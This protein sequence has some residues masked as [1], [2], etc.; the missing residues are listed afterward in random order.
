[1]AFLLE[2]VLQANGD[3]VLRIS[4]SDERGVESSFVNRLED[5]AR[6]TMPRRKGRVLLHWSDC[7]VRETVTRAQA[8]TRAIDQQMGREATAMI[9][10]EMRITVS[11]FIC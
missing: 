6:L 4:G 7:S 3:C 2:L 11:P 8:L 5:L 10:S 9:N 1:M